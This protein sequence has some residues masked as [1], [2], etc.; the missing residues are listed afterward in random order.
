[1]RVVADESA[2]AGGPNL[3]L[4]G[5]QAVADALG[6]EVAAGPPDYDSPPVVRPRSRWR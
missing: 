4:V 3:E 1:M 2:E 5:W 6:L